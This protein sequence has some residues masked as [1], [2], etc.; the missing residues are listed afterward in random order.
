MKREPASPPREGGRKEPA[1]P[2]REGSREPANP[3]RPDIP[4]RFLCPISLEVM[5]DP[6]MC[7]NG[8][9]FERD[10]LA[11]WVRG[12]GSCPTCRVEIP[13][14]T[15]LYP[16]IAL[17][18][19]IAEWWVQAGPKDTE[20]G[21]TSSTSSPGNKPQSSPRVL[22]VDSRTGNLLTFTT[23][24]GGFLQ[25]TVNGSNPRPP[26][27]TLLFEGQTVHFID[28]HKSAALPVSGWSGVV[29]QM[30]ELAAEVGIRPLI[31]F[32]DPETKNELAF[33]ATTDACMQY[34]VNGM[35]RP[36]FRQ[37]LF[38]GAR[39]RFP[40]IDRSATLPTNDWDYVLEEMLQLVRIAGVQPAVQF[41][42]PE[43]TNELTFTAI[44]DG[45]M[46][47][48]VNGK[49]P[50]PPFRELWFEGSKVKFSD[51]ERSATLPTS[52]WNFVVEQ[53]LLLAKACGIEPTVRFTDPETKNKLAFKAVPDG[54]LQYTVNGTD[55]RPPFRQLRFDEGKVK[56]L[57]INRSATLPTRETYKVCRQLM[58]LGKLAG[59]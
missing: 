21:A 11:A 57:D 32:T 46:L 8:H 26:F 28:I 20:T 36:P 34:T 50:R 12:H 54:C 27:R 10:A 53:M 9:N 24:P 29:A 31:Q 2:P 25:Y 19:N 59:L 42:D 49:D 14:V 16:N 15:D 23:K 41:V 52:D 58:S 1:N 47:Y 13:T 45:S 38:E 6:V 39:V 35:P 3:P 40:D 33:T 22:F 55:P 5:A 56:F 4:P 17:R 18:E 51:I 7:R 37:M 44:A 43:T 48:K 30:L